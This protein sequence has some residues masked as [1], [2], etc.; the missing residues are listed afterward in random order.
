M[1]DI[2]PTP[3]PGPKI[4]RV[5]RLRWVPL[6]RMVV[7]DHAQRDLKQY[8]VDHLVAHFDAEQVGTPVVNE[9]GGKFFIIDGQHRVAALAEVYDADHQVQCW[10]YVGLTEAQE[11]EKFLQLNDNLAVAALDKYRVAV[12][13]GRDAES[14]IDR[15]VRACGLVV[16]KREVEGGIGAVGTCRRG[17]QRRQGRQEVAELVEDR[18]GMSPVAIVLAF[19]LVALCFALA[20]EVFRK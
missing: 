12:E 11:A 4:E 10:A 16:S 15:I 1:S 5:A 2:N 6:N 18:G 19:I 13:A 20:L 14:D 8:R 9:R 17:H 7:S 3:K